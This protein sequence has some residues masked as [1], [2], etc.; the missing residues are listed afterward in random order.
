MTGESEEEE[1]MRE[2]IDEW[3]IEELVPEWGWRRD[4]RS[5]LQTP[6]TWKSITKGAISNF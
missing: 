6:E 4:K 1:G 5:W 3:E 2:G